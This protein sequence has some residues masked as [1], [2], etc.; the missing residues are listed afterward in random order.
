MIFCILTAVKNV[1]LYLSTVHHETHPRQVRLQPVLRPQL[2]QE[3]VDGLRGPLQVG[4]GHRSLRPS[5][6]DIEL[7]IHH[8]RRDQINFPAESNVFK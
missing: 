8:C 5:T 4:Q 6:N 7:F 2:R 1:L 3:G